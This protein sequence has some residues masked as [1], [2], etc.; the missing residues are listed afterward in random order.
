MI[1][2]Y[3]LCCIAACVC[4]CI[5]VDEGE[6]AYMLLSVVMQNQFRQLSELL[7]NSDFYIDYQ[8]GRGKRT[9]LHSAA[10]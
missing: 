7:N 1:S 3:S 6:A 4:A 10:R 9:L 5:L 2:C 8:F